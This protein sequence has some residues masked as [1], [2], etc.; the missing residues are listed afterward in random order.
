MLDLENI[1][2]VCEQHM[3]YDHPQHAMSLV[4]NRGY[5]DATGDGFL[6]EGILQS[7]PLGLAFVG[8]IEF[9]QVIHREGH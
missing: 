5:L 1:F 7:F 6:D 2:D 3:L 9:L 8:E 4:E